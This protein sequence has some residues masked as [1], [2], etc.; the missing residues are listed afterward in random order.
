MDDDFG[1][2]LDSILT[3]SFDL[4]NR[5]QGALIRKQPTMFHNLV[6]PACLLYDW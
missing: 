3:L 6:T 2:V 5:G 4:P 1:D